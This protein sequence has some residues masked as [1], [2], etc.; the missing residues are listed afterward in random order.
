MFISASSDLSALDRRT[1]A[2]EIT[3]W[4]ILNQINFLITLIFLIIFVFE[5]DIRQLELKNKQLIDKSQK[6]QLL[7]DIG[8]NVATLVHN[9]KNDLSILS[10]AIEVSEDELNE[11]NLSH[12]IVARDRLKNKISNILAIAK[13]ANSEGETK[14]EIEELLEGLIELFLINKAYRSVRVIKELNSSIPVKVNVSEISQVFENI[15]KNAFEHL[16][17]EEYTKKEVPQIIIKTSIDSNGK[18]IS[19]CDNGNGIKQCIEN[20]YFED[21]QNYNIFK[22]GKTTKQEGSGIGMVSVLKTLK[23]YNLFI[24]INTSF[25]GTN[26][27]IYIDNI[28]VGEENEKVFGFD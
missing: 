5:D 19:I 13:F 26:I 16:I 18:Y 24:K 3:I 21:C 11:T 4:H 17:S 10:M 12:L 8:S 20:G 14:F 23:K 6:S 27:K 22:V 28:N 15:I 1:P 25:D 7:A 9:M 2:V